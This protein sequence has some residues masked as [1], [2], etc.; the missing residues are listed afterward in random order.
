MAGEQEVHPYIRPETLCRGESCIRP[1][2]QFITFSQ[3]SDSL[4]GWPRFWPPRWRRK[5]K[6]FYKKE[7]KKQRLL[8]PEMLPKLRWMELEG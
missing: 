1:C 4:L 8:F 6:D 3:F 7:I 5:R 2:F